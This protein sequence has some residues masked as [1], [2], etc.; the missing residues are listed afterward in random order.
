MNCESGCY[1]T[2]SLSNPVN[3]INSALEIKTTQQRQLL[4]FSHSKEFITLDVIAFN[5]LKAIQR[6]DI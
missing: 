2:Q 4:L 1:K 6:E 5:H 3:T